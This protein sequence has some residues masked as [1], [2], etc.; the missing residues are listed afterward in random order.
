MITTM[1]SNTV[2]CRYNAVDFLQNP[3][4]RHPIARPRGWDIVILSVVILI[5]DSLFGTVI[6]VSHVMLW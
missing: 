5:S 4:N 1:E 6:A 3:H 2:W